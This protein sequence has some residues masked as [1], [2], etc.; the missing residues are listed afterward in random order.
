MTK[1]ERETVVKIIA[2]YISDN[3]KCSDSLKTTVH[4]L[5]QREIDTLKDS[6][7][8]DTNNEIALMPKGVL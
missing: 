2:N 8:I 3:R 6:T 1:I 4:Y 7:I 5:V